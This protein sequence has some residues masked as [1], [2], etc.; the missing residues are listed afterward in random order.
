MPV[1]IVLG[2]DR[3]LC[4]P[5]YATY[6]SDVPDAKATLLTLAQQYQYTVQDG[7]PLVLRSTRGGSGKLDDAL[8][9]TYATF[10]S[11]SGTMSYM[12]N[13]VDGW[14]LSY[15]H[16]RQGYGASWG[17][18]GT[19]EELVSSPMQNVTL[20]QVANHIVTLGHRGMWLAEESMTKAGKVHTTFRTLS[21]HDDADALLHLSC[22]EPAA[23]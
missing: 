18:N 16:P 5:E 11:L 2:I 23:Q 7:N 3:S 17:G 1:G 22:R 15:L 8:S 12:G 13:S 14:I 20:E 10:P 6:P 21:Y 9:H 4:T 19:E